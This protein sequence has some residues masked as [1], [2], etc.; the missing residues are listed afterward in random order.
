MITRRFTAIVIAI[1]VTSIGISSSPAHADVKPT[2]SP[3]STLSP[4][5]QYV[6]ALQQYKIDMKL[7]LDA[8]SLREQQLRLILVDFNKALKKAS[9][10]A[11]VA[12][13]GAGSKAALAAARSQAATARD[14]A[15]ALLGPEP[16]PPTAPI[17]PMMGAKGFA[18]SQKPGKKN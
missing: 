9:D 6:E 4:A 8:K 5:A 14:E 7:Y 3:T 13:K 1:T 11:R 12:G 16:V 18:P 2:P 17:K 10:E 15:V